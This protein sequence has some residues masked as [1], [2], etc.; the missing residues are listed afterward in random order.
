MRQIKTHIMYTKHG[1]I[2]YMGVGGES[3]HAKSLLHLVTTSSSVSI[4]I[5]LKEQFS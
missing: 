4:S 3:L 5:D 2:N 1:I